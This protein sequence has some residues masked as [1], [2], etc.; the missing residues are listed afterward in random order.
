[1]GELTTVGLDLAKR[2]VQVHGEDI[3]GQVV[4]RRT[5]RTERVVAFFANRPPCV[6]GMEAC[7]G[8]HALAR[9]LVK[10]GHQVRIIA[11]QF[12]KPFRVGMKNDANDA[13]AVC[14]AARQPHMRY[15]RIKT[16]AQQSV[17]AMHTLRDGLVGMRTE[18]INRLRGLLAEFAVSFAQSPKAA[19][20]GARA[21]LADEAL[22]QL[23]RQVVAECLDQ[24]KDLEGRIGRWDRQIQLHAKQD[25]RAARLHESLCGVGPLTASAFAASLAEAGDFKNGRQ[26][27]AWL[28]LTPRQH[29]TGGK[30]R[31]GGLSKQG[32][33]YLR[34][35][36]IQGA[37]SALQAAQRAK[38][39][40]LTRLQRWM[41][42]LY[43]R[44]GYHKT[45]AAIA[46]KHARLIW[47]LLTSDAPLRAHERVAT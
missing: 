23:M 12:V 38:A 7:S 47:V 9:V 20:A 25:A 30:T 42:A 15:V 32:D 3:S 6:V 45:L 46:N 41:L 35:L 16:E 24:F 26:F 19:I 17:L 37:R 29:S 44:C 11:A 36:L 4:L 21:A 5:L 8:A 2:V 14:I 22:P 34:T 40:Q 43:A 39:H 13:Q 31:L 27:A 33:A 18:I 1:M 28:G 10:Q